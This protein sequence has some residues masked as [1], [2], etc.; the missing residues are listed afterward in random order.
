MVRKE[1]LIILDISQ[2]SMSSHNGGSVRFDPDGMLYL[3]LGDG[4]DY[5]GFELAQDLNNLLGSIIRIDVRD[6]SEETPYRVPPDN[7]LVGSIR[8]P[9]GDLRLGPPESV[10]N[11]LRPGKPVP[12]GS[13]MWERTIWKK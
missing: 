10:A 11:E 13:A 1:E 7:P 6:I 3:G 2:P 12:S 9:A 8:R 5:D 4:G